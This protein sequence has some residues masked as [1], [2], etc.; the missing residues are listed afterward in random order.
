MFIPKGRANLPKL[1]VGVFVT[2]GSIGAMLATDD[3]VAQ[4]NKAKKSKKMGGTAVA[5]IAP[6]CSVLNSNTM[7]NT[8][9]AVAGFDFG[10]TFATIDSVSGWVEGTR[11]STGAVERLMLP[12]GGTATSPNRLSRYGAW[13]SVAPNLPNV[14]RDIFHFLIGEETLYGRGQT[15]PEFVGPVPVTMTQNGADSFANNPNPDP[16][17]VTG[18]RITICG[19]PATL[20]CQRIAIEQTNRFAPAARITLPG[21]PHRLANVTGFISVASAGNVRGT[22]SQFIATPNVSDPNWGA[23]PR[24]IG[25]VDS[26]SGS[27]VK[28]AMVPSNWA[29]P[30]TYTGSARPLA[31]GDTLKT[32]DYIASI[33]DWAGAPTTPEPNHPN[34]VGRMELCVT[35]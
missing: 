20:I 25:T 9:P 22:N 15:R 21:A 19:K 7:I 35:K 8:M 18:F 30:F 5:S 2:L 26:L 27:H 11:P 16:L 6:I 13:F 14:A 29:G 4:S 12:I 31:L 23:M 3:A 24:T 17:T 28:V 32:G 34:V 33:I 10:N 1:C